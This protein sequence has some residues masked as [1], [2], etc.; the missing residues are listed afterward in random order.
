VERWDQIWSGWSSWWLT[1]DWGDVPGW[2][3]AFGTI[4]AVL[5]AML[6]WRGDRRKSNR[7]AADAF[8]S[9]THVIKRSY[10]SPTGLAVWEREIHVYN[11]G[12]T[13]IVRAKTFSGQDYPEWFYESFVGEGSNI[14]SSIP[15]KAT[16]IVTLPWQRS[17]TPGHLF[18][19]FIDNV[20]QQWTRDLVSG[21]YL[22]GRAAAQAYKG[23]NQIRIDRVRREVRES[24]AGRNQ[25]VTNS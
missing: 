19:T 6:L 23:H 24:R 14:T 16:G 20:G 7:A 18:L 12:E 4:G 17:T 5:F 2:F 10:D 3:G 13:P 8:V 25:S 15:P 21:K 1:I 22:S 11:S 9:W